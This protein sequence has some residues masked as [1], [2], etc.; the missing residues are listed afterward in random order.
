VVEILLAA[1][2]FY[3]C[4]FLGSSDKMSFEANILQIKGQLA[5]EADIVFFL[6]ANLQRGGDNPR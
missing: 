6:S 1:P 3:C 5:W 2:L 4:L